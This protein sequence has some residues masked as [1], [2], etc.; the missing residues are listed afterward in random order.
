MRLHTPHAIAMGKRD[1]GSDAPTKVSLLLYLDCN[2][3]K[4]IANAVPFV[5]PKFNKS[6]IMQ[7]HLQNASAF[8][9]TF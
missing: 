2:N 9:T 6:S 8:L 1:V 4:G 7:K 3:F 5:I